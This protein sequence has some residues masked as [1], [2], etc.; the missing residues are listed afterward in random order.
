MSVIT[1]KSSF[2]KELTSVCLY[3]ADLIQP[4]DMGSPHCI[5]IISSILPESHRISPLLLALCPYGRL[6]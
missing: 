2:R 1:I 3:N 6:N 4:V 5:A